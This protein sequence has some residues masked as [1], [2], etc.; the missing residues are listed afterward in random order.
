MICGSLMST[1]WHPGMREVIQGTVYMQIWTMNKQ[2]SKAHMYYSLSLLF[3]M[4]GSISLQD[5]SCYKYN[6][7]WLKLSYTY[8]FTNLTFIHRTA[9]HK[10]WQSRRL[11]ITTKIVFYIHTILLQHVSAATGHP[12]SGNTE[13]QNYIEGLMQLEELWIEMRSHLP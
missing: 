12:S 5:M 1:I 11:S 7:A 8:A 6:Y 13:Y 9:I 3:Y 10:Q 4:T 2:L